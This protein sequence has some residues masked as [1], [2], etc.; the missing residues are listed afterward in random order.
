[1]NVFAMKGYWICPF[2]YI[3]WEG[4]I[5]LFSVLLYIRW[6]SFQILNQ[7]CINK[8]SPYDHYVLSL[9]IF[10]Q[11]LFA[12][13]LLENFALFYG[14]CDFLVMS[15]EALLKQGVE[16]SALLFLKIFFISTYSVLNYVAYF[17]EFHLEL[18]FY[19]GIEFNFKLLCHLPW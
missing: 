2:F 17:S 16:Y 6:I 13:I 19:C 10:C 11:T 18:R 4:C 3:H 15:V 14:D 8:L 9:F 1:M 7:P 12:N 5:N